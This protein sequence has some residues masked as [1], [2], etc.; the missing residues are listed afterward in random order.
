[1]HSTSTRFALR[2][3]VDRP[4]SSGGSANGRSSAGDAVGQADEV[5][6]HDVLRALEPPRRHLAQHLAL[7]GDAGRQ[8]RRRTRRCGRWRRSA[9]G[10]RDRTCHAPCRGRCGSA[11]GSRSVRASLSLSGFKVRVEMRHSPHPDYAACDCRCPAGAVTSSVLRSAHAATAAR[12]LDSGHR[13]PPAEAR[14]RRQDP[15]AVHGA[16]RQDRGGGEGRAQDAQQARRARRAADAGD[17]PAREGQIAGRR[18]AG[19]DDRVVPAAARR[20]RPPEP[21]ALRL[22]AARQVHRAARGP[23][24]AVPPAARHAAPPCR[25]ATTS[26]RPSASTRWRCC[27]ALGYRPELEECVACR[28][29][30]QPETNYWSAAA[31]GVVCAACRTEE[32]AVRPLS[33][34][35][36]SSCCGCCSTA[37]SAT[38]RA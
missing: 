20:P 34:R 11:A 25:P 16:L 28:T 5:V 29:R 10:R 38:S 19:R 37:A 36:P 27:D 12:V 4:S 30:L 13:A 3:I 1:M 17:V 21:R 32:S 31:G 15:H 7:V 35:T 22:R 2:A 14:R 23:L 6:R 33:A 24:R 26:T 9:A 8:D 18:D